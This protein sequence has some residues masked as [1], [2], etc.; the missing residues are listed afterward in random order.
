MTQVRFKPKSLRL[1]SWSLCHDQNQNNKI[2]HPEEKLMSNWRSLNSERVRLTT[3][4]I[5]FFMT[6][7]LCLDLIIYFF[8][9]SINLRLKRVIKILQQL[10]RVLSNHVLTACD[11][12]VTQCEKSLLQLVSQSSQAG[13]W[14]P[15]LFAIRTTLK[16]NG[17]SDKKGK[18]QMNLM[19]FRHAN[20]CPPRAPTSDYLRKQLRRTQHRC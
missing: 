19:S 14:R 4:L 13:V 9:K 18:V 2:N 11:S 6:H 3:H 7:S 1:W 16:G 12:S 8:K 17:E 10:V 20:R 5:G 15:L